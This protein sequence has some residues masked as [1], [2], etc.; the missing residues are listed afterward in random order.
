MIVIVVAALYF[1]RD[2]FVPL[3]LA[4]LLSF[5]LAPPVRWLRA[6]PCPEP[7]GGADGRHAS[8]SC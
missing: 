8:P 3:A 6:S 2:I 5:A 1:G 4:M 7:A